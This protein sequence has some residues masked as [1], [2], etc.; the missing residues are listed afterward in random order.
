MI[1]LGT[2]VN[3][4]SIL[5][6]GL[7]GSLLK[8][9]IPER[10]RGTIMQAVGLSVIIIGLS[11]SLQGMYKVTENRLSRDFILIMIFSLIIGAICGEFLKIDKRLDDLGN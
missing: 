5:A 4:V 2:I 1:G 3:A 8:S 7:I 9:F 10:Y 11:G 6:G